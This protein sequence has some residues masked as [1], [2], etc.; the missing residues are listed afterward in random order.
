MQNAV[1]IIQMAFEGSLVITGLLYLACWTGGRKFTNRQVLSF[2]AFGFA[3]F[4]LLN[5]LNSIVPIY[6][7]LLLCLTPSL[8]SAV[9]RVFKFVR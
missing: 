3:L 9:K 5:L 8:V 7:L 4:L 2:F 6:V 1:H